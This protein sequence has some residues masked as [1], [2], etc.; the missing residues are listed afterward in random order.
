MRQYTIIATRSEYGRVEFRMEVRITVLANT[1]SEAY[2]EV[3]KR[4]EFRSAF[5]QPA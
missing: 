3:R 5:L 2:K 1:L 4:P